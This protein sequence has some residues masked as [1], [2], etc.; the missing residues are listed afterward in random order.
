MKQFC[1]LRFF[2][3][4][5]TLLPFALFSQGSTGIN[6][7]NPSSK[8]ALD[9]KAYGKQG[10][11]IPRL[12]TSDTTSIAPGNGQNKGLVFYDS[13]TTKFWYWSGAKWL[14]I[15]G[16]PS[17]TTSWNLVGNGIDSASHFLG[18][19]AKQP[20]LIKTAGI[21]RVHI[22][23]NGKVGIGTRTP[24]EKLSVADGNIAIYRADGINPELIISGD[25]QGLGYN[26]Y[27]DDMG[28]GNFHIEYKTMAVRGLTVS[29][30]NTVGIGTPTPRAP[31]NVMT[32]APGL[33]EVLRLSG[34]NGSVG[35]GPVLSFQNTFNTNA[36][37]Y[38]NWRLAE[39]AA[40]YKG[41]W[42]GDLVFKT[43]TYASNLDA[44]TEKM[45]LT[46]DGKL[47]IG[48][49]APIAALD[50]TG[51]GN[52]SGK[53]NRT[54][55][56]NANLVPIAYGTISSTGVIYGGSTTNFTVVRQSAGL[57]KIDITGHSYFYQ[58]YV[59]VCSVYGT[60]LSFITYYDAGT[61]LY[62]KTY[63]AAGAST[64]AFFNFVVYLK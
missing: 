47:G 62:V 51:N 3:A 42:G 29:Q 49:V 21:G 58:D 27:M 31:L 45:R 53:I 4:A 22:S 38:P 20:V 1:L 2:F 35:T 6:N 39:I 16:A 18:S 48:N 25:N 34:G 32:L 11:L 63:N 13:L 54:E 17:P 7:A 33:S 40:E 55:T 30:V 5:F 15:G 19:A 59:T 57:Y 37:S 14:G 9:I 43:N 44:P 36:A 12:A 24:I 8:A 64:D 56:S 61:S 26:L 46:N 10:L 60:A 23:S 28:D 52:F 41:S 50:V